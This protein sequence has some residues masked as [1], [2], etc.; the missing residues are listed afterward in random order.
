MRLVSGATAIRGPV[1]TYVGDPFVLPA[2]ECVHF[3]SDAL[4]VMRDGYVVGFGPAS[5]ALPTLPS[6]V[7]VTHY[8]NALILPGFIDC[9]VHYPQTE[10]IG[11][12]G[13]KLI[14]WLN[15]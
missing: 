13:K 4:V 15:K 14:D 1:L 12:F 8:P 11:A 9:H 7:L 5:G 10:I 2:D 6:D 3:E